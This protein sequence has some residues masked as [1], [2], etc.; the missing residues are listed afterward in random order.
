MLQVGLAAPTAVGRAGGVQGHGWFG[1][2]VELLVAVRPPNCQQTVTLPATQAAACRARNPVLRNALPRPAQP[3]GPIPELKGSCQFSSVA[4][5]PG[6][7]ASP[8]PR[9][10]STARHTGS[11]APSLSRTAV[12]PATCSF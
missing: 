5:S 7:G 2:H 9:F 8:S 3:Y 12:H 10:T 6:H 11:R 4:R 1:A